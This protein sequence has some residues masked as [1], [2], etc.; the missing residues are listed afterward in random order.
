MWGRLIHYVTF[1]L[2]M[3]GRHDDNKKVY[4]G[5]L[6]HDVTNDH[7]QALFSKFGKIASVW[8]AR[9]PPGFAFV[10]FEDERDAN[11]AIEELDGTS[12]EGTTIKVELS[13]G[14]RSGLMSMF[15][16]NYRV[17]DREVE[18]GESDPEVQATVESVL[19]S[20]DNEQQKLTTL[21][22]HAKMQSKRAKGD[23]RVGL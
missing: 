7:L 20:R 15:N 5:N 10:T 13:K 22:A 19:N 8:I 18:A 11:D 14:N 21:Q 9:K 12:Y 17:A 2:I 16:F 3:K 23:T 1:P 4:V 6:S